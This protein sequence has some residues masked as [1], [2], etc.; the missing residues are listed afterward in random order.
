MRLAWLLLSA[1]V[2]ASLSRS[3]RELGLALGGKHRLQIA[4]QL[5]R[6]FKTY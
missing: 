4:Q 5:M 2:E 6:T 1:A 3:N